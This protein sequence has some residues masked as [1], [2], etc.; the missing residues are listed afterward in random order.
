VTSPARTIATILAGVIGTGTTLMPV[1]TVN[2]SN[3]CFRFASSTD[4]PV[5]R[6]VTSPPGAPRRV[7]GAAMMPR[8]AADKV[9][10]TVLLE[11]VDL[12]EF[13]G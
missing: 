1:S 2:G 3:Q 5:E 10:R 11:V 4:P 9:L 7:A 6:M 8:P 12:K 13:I